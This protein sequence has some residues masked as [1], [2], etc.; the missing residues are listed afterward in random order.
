MFIGVLRTPFGHKNNRE[1][2]TGEKVAI[3][4]KEERVKQTKC[5]RKYGVFP[6]C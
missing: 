3:A 5:G 6:A 4:G 2:N 1:K